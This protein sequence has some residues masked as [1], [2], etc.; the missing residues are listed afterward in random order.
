MNLDK[1]D[2]KILQMLEQNSELTSNQISK[3]TNIPITTIHNR[4]KKLKQ[5]E[6]IKNYT[7]KINFEKIGKPIKAYIQI[8]VN[9]QKLSQEE[10]AEKIKKLEN[11][12]SVDIVTGSTDILIQTRAKTMQD[13][14][15]LITH[16]LRN[17]VGIDKT[18]TMIVLKEI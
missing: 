8:S 5:N 11:I 18:Q 9:Q 15:N 4:I 16:K 13:L 14:N 6:I 3:K 2:L 10:I 17:I 7:I 1:K 12:E